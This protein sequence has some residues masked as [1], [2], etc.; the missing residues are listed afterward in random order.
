M[1]PGYF[2]TVLGGLLLLVGVALVVRSLIRPG[3]RL[4]PFAWKPLALVTASTALF[5]IVLRGAGLVPA[6]LV[7][8]VASAWASRRFSWRSSLLLAGAAAIFVSLVFVE[9]LGVPMPILGSW[10]T[11]H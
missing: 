4:A 6:T 5:G 8:V 11:G 9:A 2:P 1:G 7:L 10:M 3:A